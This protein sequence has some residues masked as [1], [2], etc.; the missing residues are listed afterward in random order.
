MEPCIQSGDSNLVTKSHTQTQA[1]RHACRLTYQTATQLLIH[2]LTDHDT[3]ISTDSHPESDVQVT[4]KY[5]SHSHI[6]TLPQTHTIT[7]TWSHHT[8]THLYP[9]SNTMK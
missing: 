4:H 6:H 2:T 8:E 5:R 7:V 9:E 3:D 1:V